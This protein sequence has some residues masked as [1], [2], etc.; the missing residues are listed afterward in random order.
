MSAGTLEARALAIIDKGATERLRK[1]AT[2]K[3]PDGDETDHHRNAPQ[4]H[5]DCL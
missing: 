3:K 2:T 5:S 1:A 4:P